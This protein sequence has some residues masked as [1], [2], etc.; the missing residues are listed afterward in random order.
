MTNTTQ[1]T[2]E[3]MHEKRYGS[4]S[5][6]VG[7]SSLIFPIEFSD[8]TQALRS[9]QYDILVN[10]P[11]AGIGRRVGGTGIIAK[12]GGVSVVA[13]SERRFVGVDGKSPKDALSSFEQLT[14]ILKDELWVDVHAQ[15]TY[16]EVIMRL[17]VLSRGNPTAAIAKFYNNLE[18]I[19]TLESIIGEP[20]CLFTIRLVPKDKLPGGSDWFDI[21][22]E[23]DVSRP[24]R[25]IV[26]EIVYRKTSYS[27]VKEFINTVDQKL[28]A[29]LDE[30]E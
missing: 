2:G 25:A 17:T 7:L 19:K 20:T 21:R 14:Q 28:E 4:V 11:P 27:H 23:P 30:L 24:E 22:L 18:G 3:P 1:S 15:G 26:V 10:L 16:Y 6:T 13:D 8:L 9:K 12:K 5:M 29:I